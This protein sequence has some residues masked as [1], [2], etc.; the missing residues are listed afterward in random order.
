MADDAEIVGAVVELRPV[1]LRAVALACARVRHG[2]HLTGVTRRD[3]AC[4]R[5]ACRATAA[6]ASRARFAAARRA[7]APQRTRNR[8]AHGGDRLPERSGTS[9]DRERGGDGAA[10]LVA[11]PR[12]E[13]RERARPARIVIGAAGPAVEQARGCTLRERKRELVAAGGVEREPFRRGGD[14]ALEAVVGERRL[15]PEAWMLRGRA[16]AASPPANPGR[17]PRGSGDGCARRSPRP[18]PSSRTSS[19]ARGAGTG[20]SVSGTTRAS[21]RASTSRR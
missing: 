20:A 10:A 12:R 2:R 21:R 5:C 14:E 11:V 3:G 13:G 17:A 15:G 8:D 18:S 4:R 16:D 1:V 19:A 9:E 7:L 6:R